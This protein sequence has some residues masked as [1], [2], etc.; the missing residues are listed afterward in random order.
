MMSVDGDRKGGNGRGGTHRVLASC[1]LSKV[2]C[3]F[4]SSIRVTVT[5]FS[6][7]FDSAVVMG[8]VTPIY[9]EEI[10]RRADASL[11][12]EILTVCRLEKPLLWG[13]QGCVGFR[14]TGICGSADTTHTRG[15]PTGHHPQSRPIQPET[16][17]RSSS[18]PPPGAVL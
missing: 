9:L 4:S 1:S 18:S 2:F 16:C 6:L 5:S 11:S 10:Q 13:L 17:A 8:R 15:L 12:L 14:V 3:L 7:G